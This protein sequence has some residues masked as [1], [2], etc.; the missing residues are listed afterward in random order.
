MT[1]AHT[2]Q[3]VDTFQAKDALKRKLAAEKG[4]TLITVPCWWDGKQDR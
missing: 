3:P 2:Y 1:T 4:M